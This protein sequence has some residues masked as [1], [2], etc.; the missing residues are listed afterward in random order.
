MFQ[1]IA[2]DRRPRT[3]LDDDAGT[4]VCSRP[5]GVLVGEVVANVQGEDL[6]SIE[7]KGLQQPQYRLAFMPVE[8]R[9]QLEDLF[10]IPFAQ[11]RMTRQHV[12][13]DRFHRPFIVSGNIPAHLNEQMPYRP[14]WRCQVNASWSDHQA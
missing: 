7:F 9:L 10:P 1:D 11:D 14:R 6:G 2:G 5:E 8:A 12:I 3:L 4:A 13:D